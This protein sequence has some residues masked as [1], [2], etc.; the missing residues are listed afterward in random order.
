MQKDKNREREREWVR[1]HS[2]L[3]RHDAIRVW[4]CLKNKWAV[5][6]WS[7]DLLLHSKRFKEIVCKLKLQ[8]CRSRNNRNTIKMLLMQW[9]ALNNPPPT[10]PWWLLWVR[11]SMS[12]DP[13]PNQ[14]TAWRFPWY[15]LSTVTGSILVHSH[16]IS[17][18]S[19]L[20]WCCQDIQKA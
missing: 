13:F 4:I 19:F 20:S 14:S 10:P 16:F 3:P 5:S 1:K 15:I 12:I 2:F 11:L 17:Q 18:V 7:S 9:H 6:E 8:I